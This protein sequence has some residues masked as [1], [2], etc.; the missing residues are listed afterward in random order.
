MKKVKFGKLKTVYRGIIFDIKQQELVF[1]N[2]E[3]KIYEYSYR[4]D[5]VMI[6]PFDKKGN[7][8]MIREY[9]SAHNKYVWFLPAGR[10]DKP[11]ES[12]RASAQRELREELGYRARDLKLLSKRYPSGHAVYNVYVFM[13]RDLVV[14]P[15]SGDESLPI[16]VMAVPLKKA[17][18][19]ALDGTIQNEFIAF[20]IVRFD[21]LKRNGKFKW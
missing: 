17:V 7:L 3:K 18:Q 19:M 4:D 1:P 8:M 14:D 12:P 21:Y 6:L 11:G 9:R 16:K 15:L 20:N 10:M 2:G 5:S 13:A